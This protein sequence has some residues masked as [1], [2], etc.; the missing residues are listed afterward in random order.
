MFSEG[1]DL[2]PVPS[3]SEATLSII[4]RLADEVWWR[5]VAQGQGGDTA[6]LTFAQLGAGGGGDPGHPTLLQPALQTKQ[7][8]LGA[9]LLQPAQQ[10]PAGGAQRGQQ[11]V[12][13]TY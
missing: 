13:S 7:Q 6:A 10:G 9:L 12:Q 3:S 2:S 11:Q 1:R 8:L 5:M 4:Q